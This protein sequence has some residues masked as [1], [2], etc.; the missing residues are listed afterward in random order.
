MTSRLP[1]YEASSPTSRSDAYKVQLL[2]KKIKSLQQQFD[3]AQ[4]RIKTL[5]KDKK[6]LTKQVDNLTAEKCKLDTQLNWKNLEYKKKEKQMIASSKNAL[7][8][9]KQRL[10]KKNITMQNELESMQLPQFDFQDPEINQVFDKVYKLESTI[11]Q[12]LFRFDKDSNQVNE[13]RHYLDC[14]F[15]T[16][17]L[18]IEESRAHKE[19]ILDL[20]NS[21]R[22]QMMLRLEEQKDAENARIA[23]NNSAISIA[24]EHR[25]VNI[26]GKDEDDDQKVSSNLSS[27]NDLDSYIS[28]TQHELEMNSMKS[29]VQKMQKS[30]MEQNITIDELNF[31]KFQLEHE[32][33]TNKFTSD[34][35]AKYTEREEIMDESDFENA[36]KIVGDDD[37]NGNYLLLQATNLTQMEHIFSLESELEE[38]KRSL[39]MNKSENEAKFYQ[40]TTLESIKKSL[41]DQNLVLEKQIGTLQ[42]SMD[43]M[44]DKLLRRDRFIAKLQNK[45]NINHLKEQ[46]LESEMGSSNSCCSWAFS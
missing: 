31:D 34:M 2:N 28:K 45:I 43:D 17:A 29:E 24:I 27:D 13:A 1:Q 38:L 20:Q 15:E 6:K 9:L 39:I 16:I 12:S 25:N 36:D 37:G 42:T 18:L 3:S 22:N 21:L 32:I 5:R 11:K 44:A 41:M 40:I 26:L 35:H 30:M 10:Y 4:K 23:Y 33:E 8:Q 7:W 19:I 14:S 46:K